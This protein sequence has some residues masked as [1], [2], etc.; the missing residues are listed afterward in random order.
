MVFAVVPVPVHSQA[1]TRSL[2]LQAHTS[3]CLE[4]RRRDG[5]T[6]NVHA[7]KWKRYKLS[8]APSLKIF[9]LGLKGFHKDALCAEKFAGDR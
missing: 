5:D 9:E 8:S 6:C 3:Y 2:Q 7:V 4:T 1:D